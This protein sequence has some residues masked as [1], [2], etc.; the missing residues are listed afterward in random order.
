MATF[1]VID[2]K[3]GEQIL[4]TVTELD[5]WAVAAHLALG[6]GLRREEILGLRWSDIDDAVHVRQTLT[7]A[8]GERH[9]AHRR[10]RRA[11]GTL[12]LPAFVA[13][14]IRRHRASQAERSA[15][16]RIGPR[17]AAAGRTR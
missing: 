12:P 15:G 6:L 14:S 9:F 2:A 17:T 8:A 5:P 16:L 7:Y 13:R 3:K 10:V 1:E 4:A 11:S